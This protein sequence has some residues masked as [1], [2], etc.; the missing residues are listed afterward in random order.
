MKKWIILTL[1]IT[2]LTIQ[3]VNA[4]ES[5]EIRLL[6]R[7]DDIG[8]THSVNQACIKSYKEGIMRT[9]ELMPNSAWFPEAVKL[10]NE[11]P[12]LE[13]GVHLVLTSEWEGTKTRPLTNAPSLVDENGYFVPM[14]YPNKTYS[15]KE[16][17]KTINW[18]STEVDNELRAQIDLALK[19]VPHINHLSPHMATML[20]SPELIKVFEKVASDY[21]LKYEYSLDLTRLKTGGLRN[22][23]GKEKEA[24][25][26]EILENLQPGNWMLLRH[27]GLDTPEM[28]A[29]SLRG[30]ENIAADRAGDTFLFTSKK[31]KEVIK[32]RGIKLITYQDLLDE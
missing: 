20:C 27:P 30:R 17:F 32:R 24:V 31:V 28:Q 6:V 11:N 25:L 1:L 23:T 21:N 22:K 15:D 10:L 13:V 26:V 9:V 7:G 4:Q 14:V 3:N 12:G 29:I 2:V 5:K 19:N 8:M 16:A 18:D